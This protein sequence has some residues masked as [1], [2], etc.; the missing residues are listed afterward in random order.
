MI[1]TLLIAIGVIW[2]ISW[3]TKDISFTDSGQA[4]FDYQDP[5]LFS[6]RQ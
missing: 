6:H 2:F 1:I 4:D 5:E 3:D